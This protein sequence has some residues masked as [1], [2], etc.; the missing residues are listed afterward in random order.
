MADITQEKLRLALVSLDQKWE[1]KGYNLAQCRQFAERAQACGV[2]LIAFPEMTLTGFSMNTAAMAEDAQESETVRQ[3]CE[4]AHSTGI[5]IVFGMVCKQGDKAAN[6]LV[7]ISSKGQA[8][9]RYVKIHPFTFAGED[10][11][12]VRG[13]QLSMVQLGDFTIGF[14][15]CYDLRF[16]EIYSALA[17]QCNLIINIANWPKRRVR[18]WRIL[19]QARA[20]ENQ[21]Y[22]VGVNRTGVDGN[23]L[24]YEESSHVFDANG[25][26][27][28][29][30]HAEPELDIYELS[31]G[32]LADFRRQFS[33]T[34]DRVPELYRSLI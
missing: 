22:M 8:L 12:F 23:G 4:I 9:A 27:L 21:L 10:K 7:Y 28:E 16:P 24:E 26:M 1:N 6:T 29:A 17:R 18:H 32:A 30:V 33:T 34:Q 2:S 11:Y 19:L 5:A 14:T 15:I 20:I 31:A 13:D 3:F 25:D